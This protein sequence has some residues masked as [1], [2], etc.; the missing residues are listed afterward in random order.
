VRGVLSSTFTLT[1]LFA[2]GATAPQSVL[3]TLPT[4]V[5]NVTITFATI[6]NAR[7]LAPHPV[8]VTLFAAA[9][10]LA[11]SERT[12]TQLLPA[13]NAGYLP[14]AYTPGIGV[15]SLTS[16]GQ[17][18]DLNNVTDT[19]TNQSSIDV[20]L[21]TRG[22][23]WT[24]AG[25]YTLA[26]P[27]SESYLYSMWKSASPDTA[28]SLRATGGGCLLFAYPDIGVNSP[29]VYRGYGQWSF[30]C[31]L[32]PLSVYFHLALV[33]TPNTGVLTVY[34]NSQLIATNRIGSATFGKYDNHRGESRAAG[35]PRERGAHTHGAQEQAIAYMC[36]TRTCKCDLAHATLLTP[37]IPFARP[38]ALFS[39][40]LAHRRRCRSA[41]SSRRGR[42]R[43]TSQYQ[44]TRTRDV[45]RT[46]C[47]R[48]A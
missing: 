21:L 7:F 5:S 15:A 2:A 4:G 24:V 25:F 36:Q 11:E 3:V 39:L 41:A 29:P 6:G 48:C 18:I 1:L 47:R 28:F 23:G 22:G 35:A 13:A 14:S 38:P 46:M 8:A 12:A 30:G 27:A 44:C 45:T 31:G 33:F 9:A 34:L 26:A 10:L 32:Y 40:Q 19:S 17:F 16:A 37:L 43:N 42:V 20:N